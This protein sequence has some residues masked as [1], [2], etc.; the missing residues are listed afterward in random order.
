VTARER[1]LRWLTGKEVE[2]GI[3][4]NGLGELET[5]ARYQRD[6]LKIYRARVKSADLTTV[7]HLRQRERECEYAEER[8]ISARRKSGG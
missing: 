4:S 1:W 5:E 8:L 6:R 2:P 3:S 7:A